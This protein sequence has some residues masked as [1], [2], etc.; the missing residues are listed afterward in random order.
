MLISIL[1]GGAMNKMILKAQTS[2]PGQ[3]LV[4]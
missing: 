1:I 4:L 3:T 2:V